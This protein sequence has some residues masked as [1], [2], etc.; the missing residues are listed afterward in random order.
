[1]PA[2]QDSP[3]SSLDPQTLYN[4]AR[5]AGAEN[6]KL[7]VSLSTG[8][9]AFLFV[10]LTQQSPPD[11]TGFQKTVI[12]FGLA[13]FSVSIFCGVSAF[14]LD[15]R[16]NYAWARELQSQNESEREKF[17]QERHAWR[18]LLKLCALALHVFF[19]LGIAAAAMYVGARVLS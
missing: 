2:E 10:G 4:R 13:C 15:A 12:C 14:Q 19:L 1:M 16:R 6:R 8:S 17:R 18:K 11:L 9:L 3:S 7:L 5:E